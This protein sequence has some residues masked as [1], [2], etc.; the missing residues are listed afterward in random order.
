MILAPI[1]ENPEKKDIDKNCWKNTR[2]K[3]KQNENKQFC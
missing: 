3:I 1:R 2:Q